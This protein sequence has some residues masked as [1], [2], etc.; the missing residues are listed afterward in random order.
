MVTM[1]SYRNAPPVP[2]WIV[3][4]DGALLFRSNDVREGQAIFLKYGLMV[5]GS[6]WG[7]GAYLGLDS[8]AAA[9]HRMGQMTAAAVARREGWTSS[10]LLTPV[11]PAIITA[12]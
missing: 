1:L 7:H 4:E 3:S 10:D 9:L 6:V 11:Q 12:P 8:P 5:N 2:A